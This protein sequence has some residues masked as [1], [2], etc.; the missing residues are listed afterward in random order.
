[1]VRVVGIWEFAVVIP[2]GM[3]GWDKAEGT[4][5]LEFPS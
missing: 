1:M 5:C 4:V 3:M 2:P